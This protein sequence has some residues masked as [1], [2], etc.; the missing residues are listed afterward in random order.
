MNWIA[1]TVLICVALIIGLVKG[2]V[3]YKKAKDVLKSQK[4]LIRNGKGV[5]VPLRECEIKPGQISVVS[6][7]DIFPTK[8]E[9]LDSVYSDRSSKKN[10]IAVCYLVYRPKQPGKELI[11]VSEPINMSIESLRLRLERQEYTNIYIDST[12]EN[13]YYFDL[14]FL[15]SA[16]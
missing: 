8:L 9:I 14:S 12:N 2:I 10:T 3:Q 1:F 7:R 5:Q 11:F 13:K 6:D 16:L 4:F 15:N